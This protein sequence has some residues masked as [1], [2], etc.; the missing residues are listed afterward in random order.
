[1]LRHGSVV[2]PTMCLASLDIKTAFGE[3]RPRHLA[4]IVESH[5][6]HGWINCGPLARDVRVGGT[7]RCSNALRATSPSIDVSAKEAS[8]LPDCG[9]RWP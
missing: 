1:M 4:Q 9:K 2:R 8:K 3:A 5:D 6:T 7:R